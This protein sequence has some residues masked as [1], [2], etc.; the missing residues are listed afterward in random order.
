[1]NRFSCVVFALVAGCDMVGA[2]DVDSAD[3][4][5]MRAQ[6][7]GSYLRTTTASIPLADLVRFWPRRSYSVLVQAV[8][9]S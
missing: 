7:V 2:A 8:K 4:D 3:A 6:K 9:A 1:M 5:L